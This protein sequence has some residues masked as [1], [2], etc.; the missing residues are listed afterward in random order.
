[1]YLGDFSMTTYQFLLKIF[2]EIRSWKSKREKKSYL[3]ILYFALT[4]LPSTNWRTL[5]KW[6]PRSTPPISH[7]STL[8]DSCVE[9]ARWSPAPPPLSLAIAIR[10]PAATRNYCSTSS[11]S[12]PWED[13]SWAFPATPTSSTTRR[14]A[15]AP[16]PPPRL[17]ATRCR[18]P[19][20]SPRSTSRLSVERPPSSWVYRCRRSS[21][22]S[23]YR[24]SS[25]EPSAESLGR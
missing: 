18:S 25:R 8:R 11:N 6:V 12:R 14:V 21:I 13:A 5:F 15:S 20:T 4:P 19:S 22:S 10:I 3:K 24:S 2:G 7:F 23:L 16:Q 9:H 17:A 1:M